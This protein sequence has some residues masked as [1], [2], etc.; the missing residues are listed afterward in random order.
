MPMSVAYP[1][2]LHEMLGTPDHYN[3]TAGNEWNL[4]LTYKGRVEYKAVRKDLYDALYE[5]CTTTP[6]I[7]S[8]INATSRQAPITVNGITYV[9][10]VEIEYPYPVCYF[11]PEYLAQQKQHQSKQILIDMHQKL[12]AIEEKF[13]QMMCDAKYI[14]VY[15]RDEDCD[16]F[17]GYVRSDLYDDTLYGMGLQQQLETLQQTGDAFICP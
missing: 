11:E 13:A 9:L 1:P 12:L 15:S 14:Y 5:S 4:V 7:I 2:F 10:D 3:I 8:R 16:D 6:Q 17:E